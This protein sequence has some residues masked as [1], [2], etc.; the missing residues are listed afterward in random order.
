[1]ALCVCLFR[2]LR[3]RASLCFIDAGTPP[4]AN[5]AHSN[6]P[7]QCPCVKREELEI[8]TVT[9]A[10]S[11]TSVKKEG[12]TSRAMLKASKRK[13]NQYHDAARI[14]QRK[15]SSGLFGACLRSC[16]CFLGV[17]FLCVRCWGLVCV[18]RAT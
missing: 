15:S 1:M 4:G 18:G 3:P 7:F 10:K 2:T 5:G 9:A 11:G 17:G 12:G 14:S 13:Q 8:G 6:Y 16:A